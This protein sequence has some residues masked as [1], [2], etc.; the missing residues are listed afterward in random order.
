[1]PNEQNIAKYKYN[2]GD[3]RASANGRAGGKAGGETKRRKRDMRLALEA[4]LEKDYN[5]KDPDH[6]GKTKDVSG[7]E[8]LALVMMSKALR[9][10]AKAWELVR[11]TAGQKPIEKIMVADVDAEV[12]EQIEN[13]VLGK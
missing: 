9:G 3:P 1:M 4:L 11:D 6:Q 2:A 13:M 8:A 12:V 10:D 5:I 7:A